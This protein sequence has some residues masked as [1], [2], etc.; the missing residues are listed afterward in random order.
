MK[1]QNNDPSS[2]DGNGKLY[3]ALLVMNSDRFCS[4][5]SKCW[6]IVSSTRFYL[7]SKSGGL[8]IKIISLF[9]L[10]LLLFMSFTVLFQLTFTFIY[11]TFSNNF[12]VSAK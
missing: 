11:S 4:K 5:M 10:F 3:D 6:K 7:V 8:K 9:S 12:S 1:W 2:Y